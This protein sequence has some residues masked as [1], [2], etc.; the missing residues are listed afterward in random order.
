MLSQAIWWGSNVLE[1]CL[2]VRGA[3]TRLISRYPVFYTYLLL[4]LLQSPIRFA[5]YHWYN[6]TWYSP[7]Y[8]TTE[9]LGLAMGCL[10]VFEIYRVALAAYPGT[11]KMARN[12]LLFLFVLALA[13]CG[14]ALW[15]DPHLLWETT[16]LQM[17][18]ALRTVESIAMV[19]LVT[20]FAS[21]S[22]PFGRNLRGILLGYGLFI[23]ERVIC[24]TF[25]PVA[26]KD[27]W[28]YAYSASYLVAL[29]LW[30]AHLWS[31]Q[32]IPEEE[33]AQLE[34]DYQRIARVTQRR[35]QEARESLVKALR[36]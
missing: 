27:F 20:V 21:Y 34:R 30:L 25:V 32:A 35:L 5:A 6:E 10:V 3:S 23:A 26:G 12:V 4:V 33:N 7:V 2:L 24:L 15:R 17:E 18:R 29:S 14:A 19:A 1:G 8:W 11:A 28:F 16:P 22:I 13:Q 31:D 36:L 9:F